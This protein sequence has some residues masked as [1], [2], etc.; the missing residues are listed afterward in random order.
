MA[1]GPVSF[2]LDETAGG[3]P[4][5]LLF[6]PSEKS[7]A[8]ENQISLLSDDAFVDELDALLVRV[9]ADGTSYL[10]DERLDDASVEML[11][12]AFHVDENDFLIVFVGTDGSEIHRSDAPV[13]ASLIMERFSNGSRRDHTPL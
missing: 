7:P 8:Y 9:F 10:R 5:I 2:R 13:Q 11:R 3:R 12:T 1:K 6:A 4:V